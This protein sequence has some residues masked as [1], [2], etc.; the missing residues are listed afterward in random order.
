MKNLIFCCIIIRTP[1]I[2]GQ[3]D[4]MQ[5]KEAEVQ[6]L[7]HKMETMIYNFNIVE[8]YE[9]KVLQTILNE[10]GYEELRD[11]SISLAECHVIDC[12]ERNE[13]INT[14][15]IAKKLN[16]TK[17]GISKIT[18]KLLNKNM[19]ESH[20]P[21]NN[22]KETYYSLKPL[23]KKIFQVHE[24]L[25]EKAAERFITTFSRYNKEELTLLG[26]FLDDLTAQIQS[27]L[28]EQHSK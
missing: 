26:R 13:R 6:T 12:I 2:K 24:M 23:G 22:Q 14:T 9:K 25:H 7:I 16:M 17:G 5:N 10:Q 28:P 19:I 8:D 21:E 11:V 27:I 4:S 18:A 1:V 3:V 15:A 20:R